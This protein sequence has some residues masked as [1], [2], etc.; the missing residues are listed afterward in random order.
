MEGHRQGAG[1]KDS[2]G[3]RTAGSGMGSFFGSLFRGR[4]ATMK[5]IQVICLLFPTPLPLLCI[6]DGE[7]TDETAEG[8]S[9]PGRGRR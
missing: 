2:S 3:R 4:A 9:C 5:G 8:P 1:A 6:S 7:A